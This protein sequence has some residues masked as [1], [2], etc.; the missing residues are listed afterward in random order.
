MT[1]QLHAALTF[2]VLLV[3]PKSPRRNSKKMSGSLGAV[4]SATTKPSENCAARLGRFT[5]LALTVPLHT[6]CTNRGSRKA[7]WDFCCPDVAIPTTCRN[8]KG[9]G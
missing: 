6:L 9:T 1:Q 2:A 7:G 8:K 4:R 5:T 3:T